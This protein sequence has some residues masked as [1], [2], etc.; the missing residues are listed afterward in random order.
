MISAN[1]M[2]SIITTKR[3]RTAIAPT[4]TTKK[5]MAKKSRL[6]R[7]SN[8]EALQNTKIRKRP[9]YTGFFARITM[10][11]ES[12]ASPANTLKRTDIIHKRFFFTHS[13]HCFGMI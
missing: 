9:G 10:I 3:K 6:M 2:F 4:Y 7:R 11:P 8:P 13:I 5:T 12:N 1:L